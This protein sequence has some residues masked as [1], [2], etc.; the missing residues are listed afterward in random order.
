MKSLILGKQLNSFLFTR[1]FGSGSVSL[2]RAPT[3]DFGF[4]KHP[5][6][7]HKLGRIP[8]TTDPKDAIFSQTKALFGIFQFCSRQKKVTIDDTVYGERMN[9][10]E[11]NDVIR[12]NRVL[13]LGSR[14]ETVIGRPFIPGA[15]VD[16]VVQDQRKD[17]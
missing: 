7:W 16:A 12:F 11:P 3:L 1:S 13:L 2:V 6:E 17:G 9:N 5:T 14:Y 4:E 10:V 8:I 15:Y